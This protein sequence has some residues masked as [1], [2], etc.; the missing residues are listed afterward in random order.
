MKRV[1][2]I[3]PVGMDG[4]IKI[5]CSARPDKRRSNLET[6]SPFPLE[7]LAEIEGDEQIERRF[8]AKFFHLHERREWFR[9]GDD[10]ADAIATIRAG[11]FDI[12]TL[13]APKRVDGVG[14]RNWTA[15]RREQLSLSL[16]VGHLERR[17]GFSCPTKVHDVVASGEPGRLATVYAYL[18]DPVANGVAKYDFHEQKRREFMSSY[19][20]TARQGRAA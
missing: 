12:K 20:D 9:Y 2:F 17:S 5:G 16:R 1:Y 19:R 14:V 7:I 4:P 8:H 10:L 15:G 11:T 3:K 6:W 13:P 18:R